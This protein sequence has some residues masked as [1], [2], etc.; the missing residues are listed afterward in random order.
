V[1]RFHKLHNALVYIRSDTA[2]TSPLEQVAKSVSVLDQKELKHFIEYQS[3]YKERLA[4]LRSGN[5]EQPA[6]PNCDRNMPPIMK[7][8]IGQ[9]SSHQ[10]PSKNHDIDTT[11]AFD[12]A[13]I[14]KYETA[15][16]S[17]QSD[18][19]LNCP[20]GAR[21]VAD[22]LI[23]DIAFLKSFEVEWQK[24]VNGVL[25]GGTES[26][27]D[28][29]EFA[30]DG[31]EL[32]DP[33]TIPFGKLPVCDENGK[34]FP[35]ALIANRIARHILD[36]QG[37]KHTVQG[38]DEFCAKMD[39]ARNNLKKGTKAFDANNFKEYEREVLTRALNTVEKDLFMSV[40]STLDEDNSNVSCLIWLHENA[41]SETCLYFILQDDD[42]AQSAAAASAA[43]A[44]PLA[45]AASAAPAVAASAAAS[46]AA[47][48]SLAAAASAAPAVA[49][50]ASP[51]AAAASAAPAAAASVAPPAAAA[52]ATPA[53]AASVAP[54]AVAASAAPRNR[55]KQRA[56]RIEQPEGKSQGKR[57][58]QPTNFYSP[59]PP[60]KRL[61]NGNGKAAASNAR[62][63]SA[64]DGEETEDARGSCQPAGGVGSVVAHAVPIS[65]YSKRV[66]LGQNR[67]NKQFGKTHLSRDA[68]RRPPVSNMTLG[69]AFH[70]VNIALLLQ[71]VY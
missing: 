48:A 68:L 53:A 52:S 70:A 9:M 57:A 18:L 54:P 26:D 66:L 71:R 47:A 6:E 11:C 46:A 51:L 1:E 50:S 55:Q 7:K 44:A 67:L 64:A 31:W 41:L 24:P 22:L 58:S 4:V 20:N 38:L 30:C 16:E 29:A 19:K 56:V 59:D 23:M 43:A 49:A 60:A 5:Y 27:D 28:V 45:A 69:Q 63:K 12:H 3:K 37:N 13:R 25:G 8:W 32:A 62:R 21:K 36:T 61:K 15:N 17:F 39:T 2:I 42:P 10:N 14:K 35:H 34:I 33:S 65:E 40:C